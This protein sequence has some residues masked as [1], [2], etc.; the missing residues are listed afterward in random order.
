M[1]GNVNFP[2]DLVYSWVDGND[3]VWRAKKEKHMRE[4]G[5]LHQDA[6]TCAR[7]RDNDELKY[8][9]RSAQKF[10]PWINHIYIVTDGQTPKWLNTKHPKIS[11]VDHKQIMPADALPTFNSYAIENYIDNIPGLSEYFLYSNDDTMFG[12]DHIPDDFFSADGVPIN[13]VKLRREE[14]IWTEGDLGKA[15]AAKTGLHGKNIMF[16]RKL[17]Y[18]K[19]GKKYYC[20]PSHNIEPLR[21]SYFSE[22]KGVFCK[23]LH[24]TTRN[25][26][27]KSPELSWFVHI[28][29]N[30][31]L[32][33]SKLV[34]HKNYGDIPDVYEA[35]DCRG[36]N[37][38]SVARFLKRI[39]CRPRYMTLDGRLIAGAILKHK[40]SLFCINDTDTN[41][42]HVLRSNREFFESYFPNKSEFEL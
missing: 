41:D 28:L 13:I 17:V 19:T 20:W 4:A 25:K 3:P 5:L 37:R 21:K 33:R 7:F 14:K 12:R 1:D 36:L 2:I 16:V 32:G 30:N 6:K 8:S 34:L 42:A 40:P 24:A 39:F 27:R 22:T 35:G 9:L 38:K 18:D 23:E 31:A 11:V 26:F 29:Y 10:A 15:V